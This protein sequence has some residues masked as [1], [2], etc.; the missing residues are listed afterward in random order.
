MQRIRSIENLVRSFKPALRHL[1]IMVRRWSGCRVM[2]EYEKKLAIIARLEAEFGPQNLKVAD[3]LEEFALW[4][5]DNRIYSGAVPYFRRSLDIRE[6]NMGKDIDVADALERWA[7]C[8]DRKG[9]AEATELFDRSLTIRQ[10]VLGP[11]SPALLPGLDALAEHYLRKFRIADAISVRMRGLE[12]AERIHGAVSTEVAARL[13]SIGL[14]RLTMNDLRGAEPMFR[15]A[16]AIRDE[17]GAPEDAQLVSTLDG[18]IRTLAAL[19]RPDEIGALLQRSL[20][21]KAAL[22]AASPAKILETFMATA[23]AVATYGRPGDLTSLLPDGPAAIWPATVGLLL[24]LGRQL[25]LKG[26]SSEASDIV[27]LAADI[28]ERIFSLSCDA[29]GCALHALL[30]ADPN[31]A[32]QISKAADPTDERLVEALGWLAANPAGISEHRQPN[33]LR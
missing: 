17:I 14:T 24:H 21:V 1:F 30:P 22:F 12:I 3:A 13:H 31:L 5:A 29:R 11:T 10:S 20:K 25:I 19:E 4:Y 7:Q 8:A 18:L 32:E 26:R 9:K 6:T 16:L 2:S 27:G 15:R 33:I 28:V 23:E